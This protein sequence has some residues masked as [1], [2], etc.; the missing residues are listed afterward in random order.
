MVGVVNQDKPLNYNYF[1]DYD[2]QTGRYI[3]SDPIGLAGGS[4]STYGYA[5][6][7]PISNVDPTGLSPGSI[8]LKLFYQ[9]K[10]GSSCP[11]D[12]EKS[13]CKQVKNDAIQSCSD[14]TLPTRDYGISFQRCVNKYIEDQGCGPGGTPLPESSPVLPPVPSPSNKQLPSQSTTAAELLF[15]ALLGLFGGALASP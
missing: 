15:L 13:R 7:N 14:S 4:P 1:R 2:P 9:N 12:D 5:G 10:K 6:N 3:E 8:I 11:N